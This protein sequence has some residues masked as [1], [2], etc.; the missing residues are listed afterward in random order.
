MAGSKFQQGGFR[1]GIRDLLPWAPT[2]IAVGALLFMLLVTMVR[3]Y[4]GKRPDDIALDPVPPLPP[5]PQTAVVEP[6]PIKTSFSYAVPP[7]PTTRPP[8]SRKPVSWSPSSPPPTHRPATT[9]PPAP[10]VTGRYGIVGTYDAEFIGE[11]AISNVTD[12]PRDWVVSLRFPDNVG[13]LRT[14]WVESAPQATLTRS[15][16]SYV[17]HSG[18]PVNARSSV[19]LRFQFARTGTGD[20]P[21]TCTVNATRCG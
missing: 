18:V 1:D 8:Y 5:P 6:S 14:S 16:D 4:P 3:L 13:D 12:V 11:V 19:L 15:G 21:T 10:T 9:R 17:W 20:R 2:V 7:S